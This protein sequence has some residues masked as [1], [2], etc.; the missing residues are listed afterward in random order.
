[1]LS[2]PSELRCMIISYL[3]IPSFCMLKRACKFF[4]QDALWDIYLKSMNAKSK[5]LNDSESSARDKIKYIYESRNVS[6]GKINAMSL[7]YAL[8]EVNSY[9]SRHNISIPIDVK[10]YIVDITRYIG[11]D[12]VDLNIAPTLRPDGMIEVKLGKGPYRDYF[13]IGQRYFIC[14]QSLNTFIIK[15]DLMINYSGFKKILK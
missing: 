1:M 13:S 5:C 2:L 8:S 3:R 14:S 11:L 10:H 9:E 7:P 4:S 12:M 6:F 15:N